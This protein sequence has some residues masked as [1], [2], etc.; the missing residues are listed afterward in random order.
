MRTLGDATYRTVGHVFGVLC[1]STSG[2]VS[3]SPAYPV[4]PP[5]ELPR[6]A[7][8]IGGDARS[9]WRADA[10]LLRI[11]VRKRSRDETSS[12]AY[13]VTLEFFSLSDGSTLVLHPG[14]GS[15]YESP[16]DMSIPEVTR[17]PIPD[18]TVDLPEA[19]IAAKKAGMR[20]QLKQGTLAVRTPRG[21]LPVL[22]WSIESSNEYD[23]SP[24]FVDALTGIH[25]TVEQVVD[26]PVGG[27]TTLEASETALKAA[28]LPPS[29]SLPGGGSAWMYFVLKPLLEAKD[30]FDCHV[31]GGAWTWLKMCIP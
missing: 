8:E 22:V 7:K 30:V 31:R 21:R 25:L 12:N 4:D 17:I 28:L 6:L 2:L 16:R 9:A 27:D 29:P 15:P 19:L 11:D 13:E 14:W 5:A 10:W 1:L 3:V 23:S 24:Y 20:G 18:F 26:P